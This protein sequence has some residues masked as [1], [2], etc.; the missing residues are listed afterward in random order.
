[1]PTGAFSA[2]AAPLIEANDGCTPAEISHTDPTWPFWPL[3]RI[4]FPAQIMSEPTYR[5]LNNGDR[6]ALETF[7]LARIES[8]MFLLGNA[9][10]EGLVDGPGRYQGHYAGAF[11]GDVGGLN[12]CHLVET[13]LCQMVRSAFTRT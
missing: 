12:A 13:Y 9:Q 7:L 2:R 10:S 3:Q 1:M 11:E 4:Q 8:S 6:R 5:I